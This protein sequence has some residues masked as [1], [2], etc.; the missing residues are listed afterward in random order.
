MLGRGKVKVVIEGCVDEAGRRRI[1]DRVVGFR[2][3]V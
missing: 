1:G 2:V 3:E